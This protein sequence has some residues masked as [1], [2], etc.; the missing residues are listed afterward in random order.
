MG[1]IPDVE[2]IV[3]LVSRMRQTLLFS[4]TMPTAI[5]R[6]ADAF[7][8]NPKEI[9]VAPPSTPA[10]TVTQGLIVVAHAGQGGLR[11]SGLLA[12]ADQQRGRPYGIDLLQPQAR[13]GRVASV[14]DQARL[15]CRRCCTA[16][17][18]N[19]SAPRCWIASGRAICG[20]LVCS[21][22][23]ARGLDIEDMSH[24][25][26]FDVPTNPE[27]YVHRIGRTGRAGRSG[28]SLHDRHPGRRQVRRLD[29]SAHRSANSAHHPRRHGRGGT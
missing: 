17:W 11:G 27:D 21:D 5:R 8:S 9:G 10:E 18:R 26:N 16:T 29:R 6:L 3:S 28:T 22:V 25:F 14:A 23:A 4:A 1:F 13:C 24:V 15:R 19:R 20:L 2:R 7:L 12:Q